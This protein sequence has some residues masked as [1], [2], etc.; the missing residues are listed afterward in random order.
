MRSSS[1][2]RRV[3]RRSRT[4]FT[5]NGKGACSSANLPMDDF[6]ALNPRDGLA[7]ALAPKAAAK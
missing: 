3:G 4:L 1:G 2:T 6:I 5:Y 7:D